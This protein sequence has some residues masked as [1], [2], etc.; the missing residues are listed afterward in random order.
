MISSFRSVKLLKKEDAGDC[1]GDDVVVPDFRVV[2]NDGTCLLVEVKNHY[3]KEPTRP[4][5]LRVDHLRRMI[6]YADLVRTELRLAIYWAPWN[7][8]TLNDPTRMKEKGRFVELEFVTATKQ[9]SMVDLGDYMLGTRSPLVMRWLADP[10]MPRTAGADGGFTFTIGSVE[11]RCGGQIIPDK[12]GQ[13][14]AFQFM[15]FGGW[16]YDGPYPEFDGEGNIAAVVHSFA[17]KQKRPEQGFE[18]L[19]F[20]SSFFSLRYNWLTLEDGI[21]TSL[22]R[23]DDPS[24]IGLAITDH[25]HS[26]ALPIWRFL[27]RPNLADPE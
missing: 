27:I 24:R 1:Y 9:N 18:I 15:L 14:L 17:P 11:M 10:L 23:I 12:E 6:R 26:E 2:T 20:R 13:N 5:R 16:D 22:R 8:W 25:Y 7:I 3:T 19:G 4:F 21:V